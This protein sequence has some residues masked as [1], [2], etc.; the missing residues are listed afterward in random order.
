MHVCYSRCQGFKS[1]LILN[2]VYFSKLIKSNLVISSAHKKQPP[3]LHRAQHIEYM[4]FV[5]TLRILF[6]PSILARRLLPYFQAHTV[7]VS[8]NQ[9][10]RQVLHKLKQ[11][12]QIKWYYRVA[13]FT[14]KEPLKAEDT[15]N[16]MSLVTR[17]IKIE[18]DQD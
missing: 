9:P 5:S 10:L 18:M 1:C 6:E 8:I 7:V 15:I 2:G 4:T 13:N 3:S 14:Y 12:C 17:Q 11:T 16:A